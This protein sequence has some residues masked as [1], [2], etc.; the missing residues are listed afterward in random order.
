MTSCPTYVNSRKGKSKIKN[1]IIL[2][3]KLKEQWRQTG[4]KEVKIVCHNINGLKTK[5]WKLVNL[6][7]WAEEEDITV[8]ELIETNIAERE[9]KFMLSN[10]GTQYKGYW[11]S[12]A[13]DKKKGSSIGI[14]VNGKWEK[15]VGAVK[16]ENEYM[17]SIRMY[18]KQL[19]LVIIG[20]YIPPNDK[21]TSRRIQQKLVEMVSGRKQQEQ[22]IILGDFNHTV[23]N[24]LDRQNPQPVNYKRLP[25]FNWLKKQEFADTYRRLHPDSRRYTWSNNEAA[26]R[27]DYIWVS[28]DLAAGLQSAEID[29]AEGLT[30]S[31][32]EI[33]KAEIWVGHVTANNSKAEARQKNQMR[34][35]YLYEEAKEENWGSSQ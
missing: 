9:G 33:I 17:I 27:V 15:H 25:I 12:A 10:I 18:F 28:E 2:N 11:A 21:I 24:I 30:E 32:H 5:G 35:I 31:D 4:R 1:E 26:T 19:E 34:T 22:F 16:R 6:V 8:L 7:A 14:L 3:N 29:E 20:V 13:E 23:D